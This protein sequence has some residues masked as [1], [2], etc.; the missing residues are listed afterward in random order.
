MTGAQAVADSE[1]ALAV[2]E[3]APPARTCRAAPTLV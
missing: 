3:V 1:T 2:A